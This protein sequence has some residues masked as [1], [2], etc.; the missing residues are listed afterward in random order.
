MSVGFVYLLIS[1]K[2]AFVKIGGTDFAPPLRLRQINSTEPYASHGPWGLADFRHVT[3]WREVEGF[4]HK[5]FADKRVLT[6]EAAQD[7]KWRRSGG[8]WSLRVGISKPSQL[9]R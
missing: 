5:A 1:P 4:L 8:G 9:R 3:D 6:I 2:T 7:E